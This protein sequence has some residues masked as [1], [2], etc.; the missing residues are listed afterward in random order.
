MTKPNST[1]IIFVVDRSGSMSSIAKAMSDGFDEFI[2][3]QKQEP[4]E[5][6]VTATQFD[7]KYDVLYTAKPLNEV[8]AYTLEPRGMTALLDAIGKTI[9]DTGS[10]LAKMTESQRPSQV[11]FV[12]ITDGGENS[13]QEFKGEEGRKRVFDMITHQ[14]EK[15]QWEFVFLGANQ[16]AIAVGTSLGISATN[17]VTYDA[18]AVGSKGLMRGLSA[19]VARY[20]SSGQG[21]MD[22][23]YDQAS[24]NAAV[25]DEDDD[26]NSLLKATPDPKVTIAGIGSTPSTPVKP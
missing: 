12:I 6:K 21:R 18:N 8:T 22:N 7:D 24:Y 25:K 26:Q 5:C 2:N 19:N 17:S 16:D 13:S 1:E 20:R 3:K 23:L 10:R 14:R 4:G 9:I 15:Y 11:L